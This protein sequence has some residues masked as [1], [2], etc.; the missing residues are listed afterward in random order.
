MTDISITSEPA[1]PPAKSTAP[2][3]KKRKMNAAQR[4]ALS[5]AAK[6][7][8]AAKKTA[9]PIESAAPVG[10]GI[11]VAPSLLPTPP[12][13]AVLAL[14]SQ[15]VDLVSQRHQARTMLNECHNAYLLA[16]SRFQAA[17]SELKGIEAEVQYRISLIAQLENR[18]SQMA[19]TSAPVLQMPTSMTGVSSEPSAPMQRQPGSTSE[20]FAVGS[21]DDLRREMR[22]MM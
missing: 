12:S 19:M 22:G 13:Q 9:E 21:A 2:K 4:K 11:T 8:W 18:P 1:Q 6:A 3:T 15:V 5:V 14:Q 10:N 20:R 17:E 7:R 16:Q